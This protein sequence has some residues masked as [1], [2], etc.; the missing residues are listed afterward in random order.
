[1]KQYGGKKEISK[2]GCQFPVPIVLP[3]SL[4]F[5]GQ[6]GGLGSPHITLL[7]FSIRFLDEAGTTKTEQKYS[8]TF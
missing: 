8:Q 5:R 7:T 6:K 3:F 2:K 1:M 4:C